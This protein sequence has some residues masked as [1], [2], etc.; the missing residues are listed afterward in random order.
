W[1]ASESTRVE[2]SIARKQ[3]RL[4]AGAFLPKDGHGRAGDVEFRPGRAAANAAR[5]RSTGVARAGF[6][7]AHCCGRHARVGV[8][9]H[10]QPLFLGR[11]ARGMGFLGEILCRHDRCPAWHSDVVLGHRQTLRRL[12]GVVGAGDNRTAGV[13][14]DSIEAGSRTWRRTGNASVRYSAYGANLM[15][16]DLLTAA[17]G[18]WDTALSLFYPDA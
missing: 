14:T 2:S 16:S 15:P 11:P 13:Q 18:A 5:L 9:A 4:R 7:V 3:R 6:F 8:S 17:R 12:A 10:R 1:G